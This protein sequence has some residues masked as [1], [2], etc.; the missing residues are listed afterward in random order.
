MRILVADDNPGTL[1]STTR[2]LRSEGFDV[3]EAST[4]AKALELAQ[5]GVDL[6]ILD[7]NMPDFSGFEVCAIL[8]TRSETARVPILHLSATMLDVSDRI[9]GLEVGA[10]A[11]LTHPLEP[12]MLVATVN[13]FL[14]AKDLEEA[15]RSTDAKYR[16][17]FE[18]ALNGIALVSQ[19][20]KVVD[21]NPAF[22]RFLGVAR[23][24]LAGNSLA[25][26]APEGRAYQYHKLIQTARESGAWQG[27]F[28][29][30]SRS[31]Q[32]IHLEWNVSSEVLPGLDLIVVTD[33]SA[34]TKMEAERKRLLVSERAARKEAETA[35]RLKDEFLATL[36][37]ELRTPLTAILGWSQVLQSGRAQDKFE[38]GIDAIVRNSVAQGQLI[39]D[40]LDV[41]RINSGKLKLEFAKFDARDAIED[42]VSSVSHAAQ[43]R[44]IEV[45]VQIADDLPHIEA[46]RRRMVQ[47]IVNLLG[48]AVKFTAPG[49]KVTL[50]ATKEDQCIRFD[51]TDSGIG[52]DPE[53]LPYIFDRF[54]QAEDSLTRIHSGLGLGL[55]IAR[56]LVE[57]HGG[58]VTAKSEGLG[59]GS[60][61]T[62]DFPIKAS[63]LY[64]EVSVCDQS[65]DRMDREGGGT[66]KNLGEA[67][68]LLVE[69]NVDTRSLLVHVLRQCG[70]TVLAVENADECLAS[71]AAFTPNVLVTDIGLPGKDGYQL[72][73]EVRSK[74][75][76]EPVP[77]VALTAF[78]THEDTRKLREAGFAVHLRKPIDQSA[79]VD[80][81][82][83]LIK[84]PQQV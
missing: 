67:R 24:D 7:I 5:E 9:R 39:S 53:F 82:A 45:A 76:N 74:W 58:V 10:D 50:R 29:L 31:G 33:I 8:R 34:E 28:P 43:S 80:T 73:L 77:S 35:N 6:V 37:H 12:G 41:S 46:D 54:R 15:F 26:F 55:A 2:V 51:V 71:Y 63:E 23:A 70:A 79:L 66:F 78:A 62:A 57:M 3:F 17:V 27:R 48:N 47:V 56:N 52:I 84:T 4:G 69:D 42:A 83:Q 36:S 30:R 81:V 1:Y 21:A 75:P 68:I 20:D 60:Q 72:L 32:A 49:G 59:K 38:E 18:N 22:C 25:E 19:T 16:A 13:A 61:F 65:S 64:G 11:Y 44:N 40:L 14:R